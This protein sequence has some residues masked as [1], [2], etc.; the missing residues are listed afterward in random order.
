MLLTNA[1]IICRLLVAHFL[2]WYF[3]IIHYLYNALICKYRP[4][5]TCF[6]AV[7][8]TKLQHTI[9]LLLSE[10]AELGRKLLLLVLLQFIMYEQAF[11]AIWALAWCQFMPFFAHFGLIILIYIYRWPGPE[12][13]VAVGVWAVLLEFASAGL[14]PISAHL[15]FVIIPEIFNALQHF[16]SW[17]KLN[18]WFAQIVHLL[19]WFGSAGS[20]S[21]FLFI[22][23]FFQIWTLWCFINQNLGLWLMILLYTTFF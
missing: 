6:L 13:R 16:S 22:S 5:I 20:S 21:S 2:N 4:C 19:N 23:L 18:F 3:W 1:F 15:G 9:N 10:A 14:Q 7:L 8:I 17:G 12:F 11:V